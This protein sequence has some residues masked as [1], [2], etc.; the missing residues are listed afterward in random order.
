MLNLEA[1]GSPTLRVIGVCRASALEASAQV[2]QCACA[3]VCFSCWTMN[4]RTPNKMDRKFQRLLTLLNEVEE[5]V[6]AEADLPQDT[7]LGRR[8]IGRLR[9][10]AD[11][12]EP[13][14][15]DSDDDDEDELFPLPTP[16]PEIQQPAMARSSPRRE[17]HV[18]LDERKRKRQ[19]EAEALAERLQKRKAHSCG[20]SYTDD[21]EGYKFQDESKKRIKKALPALK[22]HKLLFNYMLLATLDRI[23]CDHCLDCPNEIN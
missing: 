13:F 15:P 16:L 5:G 22:T 19:R 18:Q 21:E 10:V 14:Y 11:K 4:I 8:L 20:C 3:Y 7:Q 17:E 9:E 23:N 2:H 1:Q 12:L 6:A